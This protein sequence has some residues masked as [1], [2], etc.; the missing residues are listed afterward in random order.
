MDLWILSRQED[1][2]GIDLDWEGLSSK[3]EYV[4]YILLIRQLSSAL[5]SEGLL[6]SI[7]LHAKQFLPKEVYDNVDRVNLMAY[8]M[9]SSLDDDHHASHAKGKFLCSFIVHVFYN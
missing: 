8:D 9:I 1:L 4:S 5:H 7:A 6:L 3:E 2:N